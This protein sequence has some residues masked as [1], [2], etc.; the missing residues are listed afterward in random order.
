MLNKKELL[1]DYKIDKLGNTFFMQNKHFNFC[2][3]IPSS[4]LKPEFVEGV[5]YFGGLQCNFQ[6]DTQEYKNL[7]NWLCEII[8]KLIK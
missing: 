8:E 6:Q 3:T 5:R 2:Y 7:E 1:K 4:V